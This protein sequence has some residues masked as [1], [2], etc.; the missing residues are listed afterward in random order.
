M[1]LVKRLQNIFWT[2]CDRINPPA[3]FKVGGTEFEI[4]SSSIKGYF[5]AEVAFRT[6][7]E[8]Y[9]DMLSEAEEK[10]VFYDVGANTGFYSCLMGLKDLSVCSF[11]PNPF[12]YPELRQN[13]ERNDA[14]GFKVLELAVSD[15]EGEALFES[16][17][18]P[19]G[20]AALSSEDSE[21]AVEVEKATIDSLDLPEPDIIK[22]DIEGHELE[23]LRGMKSTLNTFQP[24]IYIE[25]HSKNQKQ[26]IRS[27]LENEGF[28]TE[29]LSSRWDGNI[30]LKAS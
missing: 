10:D 28:E 8:V 3:K 26:E 16:T 27:F 21:T 5:P 25:A 17:N 30:F 9:K 12:T 15:E 6:E 11:E 19:I 1:D 20:R 24:L 4:Y 18:S 22:I 29:T 2:L 13:L 14:D 7:K 23:A